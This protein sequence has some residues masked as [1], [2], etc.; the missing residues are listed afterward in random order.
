MFKRFCLLFP[1]FL[2]IALSFVASSPR[3]DSTEDF[4]VWLQGVRSEAMTRGIRKSTLDAALKDLA[5]IERVLELD[6][7]QPEFTQTFW[8][9]LDKRVTDT[10][11]ERGRRLLRENA[12]LLHDIE[13]RYGVEGRYLVSFWGL[14]TNFGDYTGGFPVIGALATLAHNPRRAD[15]FRSQLFDALKILDEGHISPEAMMGSWAGA[16]GQPQFMPSTFAHYAV[17]FDGDGRRDIWNSLPD[18]FASAANYLSKSGW[19][20]NQP[21]GEEVTL[22]LGFDL[23]QAD[24]SFRKSI[25]WWRQAGVRRSDGAPLAGDDATASI[26]LP[27]GWQGPAFLVRRNFRT[28]LIWNRSNLYAVAV[29]H[30]AD[31]LVDGGPFL[32]RRPANDLP[33]SRTQVESLQQLLADRGFAPGPVDGVIGSQTRQAIKDFQR[34]AGLPIDGHPSPE[35]IEQIGAGR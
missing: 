35:L 5:P 3:A 16:M 20:P 30:L 21:W 2:F 26:L 10:R 23:E 15:F 27:A 19:Q 12:T 33:M 32:A 18:I 9:Y 34:Q 13:Q 17:D 14:E 22:P 25:D 11:I 29:G 7:K 8:S 6:S 1:L 31:R 28:I 4:T 24:L